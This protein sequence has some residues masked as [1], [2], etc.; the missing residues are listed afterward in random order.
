MRPV[1]N[2][3]SAIGHFDPTLTATCELCW[4]CVCDLVCASSLQVKFTEKVQWMSLE[5]DPRTG[6][7]QREDKLGELLIPRKK[8]F[9][10][11]SLGKQTTPPSPFMVVGHDDL[12]AEWDRYTLEY[13][14]GLVLLPG[15]WIPSAAFS[16]IS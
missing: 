4:W 16:S 15:E 5:F 3:E 10:P 9:T 8:S 11:L 14:P 13:P 6:F 7:A 2:R 1:L 12:H